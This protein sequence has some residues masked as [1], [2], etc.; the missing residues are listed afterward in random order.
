MHQAVEPTAEEFFASPGGVCVYV[1]MGGRVFRVEF[2]SPDV[3]GVVREATAVGAAEALAA[4]T[5]ALDKHRTQLQS[6]FER[7]ARESASR[8]H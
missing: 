1:S 8:P 3:P 5:R 6:L 4:A 7:V 2:D